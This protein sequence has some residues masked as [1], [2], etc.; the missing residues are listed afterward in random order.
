MITVTIMKKIYKTRA[1]IFKNMGVNIQGENFPEGVH[2]EREFDW[3]K[4]SR[5]QFS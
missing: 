1:G 5:W 2:Q 4:F 3:W